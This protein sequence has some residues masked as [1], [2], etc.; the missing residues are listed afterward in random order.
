MDLI[1]VTPAVR[2][3]R[4]IQSEQGALI[5][6]IGDRTAQATGLR[7]GDV[8]FQINRQRVSRAEQVREAFREAA[9]RSALRVY[10]ER[11]GYVSWTEFY[12]R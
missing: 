4:R 10:V 6:R 5:Y 2:Q 8:I 12:V 7:A 1:T 3:E 9:G 11:G